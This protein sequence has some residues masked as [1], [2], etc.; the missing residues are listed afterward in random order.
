M[1]VCISTERIS[2]RRIESGW[3][4]PEGECVFSCAESR[5]EY[6][7]GRLRLVDEPGLLN[8]LRTLAGGVRAEW[9]CCFFSEAEPLLRAENGLGDVAPA[10]R[11][12]RPRDAFVGCVSRL[13]GPEK[14]WL[15]R[16]P[17]F[18]LLGSAGMGGM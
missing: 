9:G 8:G 12:D 3:K 14:D 16:M 2:R 5:A 18:L 13:L 6:A 4:R 15:R 10:T 17:A 7:G 11:F 1:S